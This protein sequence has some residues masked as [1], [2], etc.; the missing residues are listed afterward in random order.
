MKFSYHSLHMGMVLAVAAI[1]GG[2]AWAQD[3]AAQ[4]TVTTVAGDGTTIYGGDG[5][6]AVSV[7][8]T[9]PKG[10]AVDKAGNLYVSDYGC[11]CVRKI[12]PKGII[13]TVAG[14]GTW[15][16]S[17]DE[18]PAT[19]AGFQDPEALAVVRRGNLYI[20]DS[21]NDRIR[22][23]DPKGMISTFAGNGAPGYSGDGGPASQ[24]MISI[25][26]A[27]GLALDKAGNLY[28]SDWGNSRIRKVDTKGI[29][30]TLTGNGTSG[31]AGDGGSALSAE[32]KEPQ[33]LVVDGGGNLY[34]A[35]SGNRRVRKVD[36]QGNIS[37][38]AGNGSFNDQGAGNLAVLTGLHPINVALDKNGE[39]CVA[40]VGNIFKV[41]RK[42]VLTLFENDHSLGVF[43]AL[44]ADEQGN[45]YLAC[46]DG[47]IR[48]ISTASSAGVA[49]STSLD[50]PQALQ[51]W[52]QDPDNKELGKT[53]AK[54]AK[55][56]KAKQGKP[57]DY[58]RH[59]EHG[60]M[61]FKDAQKPED[62]AAVVT[63]FQAATDA[64]P[65]IADGWYNLG[66][67]K[68]KAGDY[69]GAQDDLKLYL[70]LA[71]KAKDA[72]A[73]RKSIYDLEYEAGKAAK[74][75]VGQAVLEKLKGIWYCCFCAVKWSSGIETTG[76]T[77][78]ETQGNNWY[79]LGDNT[80]GSAPVQFEFLPDGTVKMGNGSWVGWG[81]IGTNY[82]DGDLYG[83]PNGPLLSDIHWEIRTKD[84]RV[85]PVYSSIQED[86]SWFE[87]SG[88]RPLNGADPN[89]K[90]HYAAFDR[91]HRK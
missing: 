27:H 17:G 66:K 74:K 21:F 75:Q 30:T 82:S 10:I 36:P 69:L 91:I 37:T 24:A 13:T 6:A 55:A 76:C 86:G 29:I 45:F 58:D 14:N 44:T 50:L 89:F 62:F 12:D 34:F 70:L 41:D 56:E 51:Q 61:A 77:L 8:I 15:G 9:D 90:Y 84:G 57:E 65:W 60:L 85:I 59:L 73:V 71:P 72:A 5:Q 47:M 80:N 39:L 2:A 38:V 18:G 79:R 52:F 48:R 88:D 68:E 7:G 87:F 53:V 11:K 3:P 35:D 31:F 32:L 1:L 16:F 63:E 78:E 54:L 83:I 22:K 19:L 20:E 42:G 81:L 25:V 67:A 64:A 28:F 33:G 40:Q 26:N 46:S 23:V 49:A 4:I 43:P